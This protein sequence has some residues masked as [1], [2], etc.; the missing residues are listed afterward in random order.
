[1]AIK[2]ETFQVKDADGNIHEYEVN[3][4]PG[5]KALKA[6]KFW[7]TVIAS[8][9]TAMAGETKDKQD[10]VLL[11][12]LLNKIDDDKLIENIEELLK[13]EV[14]RDGKPVNFDED[15][16][17]NLVEAFEITVKILRLNFEP[18]WKSSLG[19]TV[20]GAMS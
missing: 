1:M 5:R 19:K 4:M 10:E 6:F 2:L 8:L 12:E 16:R 9:M 11:D 7:A 14:L 18:L 20:M 17:G 3:Q 13:K 15:Y